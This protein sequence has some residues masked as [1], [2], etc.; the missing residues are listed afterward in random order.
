[1]ILSF[2]I[3]VSD[4]I[5][6]AAGSVLEFPRRHDFLNMYSIFKAWCTLNIR[7]AASPLVRFIEE[8]PD[9]AQGWWWN[10]AKSY[11]HLRK[12]QVLEKVNSD[13]V[14]T[15]LEINSRRGFHQKLC[16][17]T[18]LKLTELSDFEKDHNASIP[19]K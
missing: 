13:W 2:G 4:A 10:Q 11:C 9:H 18:T 1:M 15:C 6:C 14:V 8:V 3:V 17:Q 12:I 19:D 7:R 16:K 5:C